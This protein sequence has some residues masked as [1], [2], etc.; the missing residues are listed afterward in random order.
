MTPACRRARCGTTDPN[1]SRSP[2]KPYA[3]SSRWNRRDRSPA[4][5]PP[6][7]AAATLVGGKS[8]WTAR[9]SKESRVRHGQ[10]FEVAVDTRYLQFYDQA[11]GLSIR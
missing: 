11:S 3:S 9:V 1:T 8:L 2:S 4:S 6:A 10:P 7:P 5:G